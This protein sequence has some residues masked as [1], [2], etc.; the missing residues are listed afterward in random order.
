MVQFIILT[1]SLVLELNRQLIFTVLYIRI[2]GTVA[3]RGT[4][5]STIARSPTR[6]LRIEL[7]LVPPGPVPVRDAVLLYE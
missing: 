1:L 3:Q 4:E 2:A 5:C 7:N 6:T